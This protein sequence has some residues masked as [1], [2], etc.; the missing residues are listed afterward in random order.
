[1]RCGL[2]IALAMAGALQAQTAIPIRQL[3]P[4]VAS[5]TENIGSGVV[6]R[7]MSDGRL[8]LVSKSRGRIYLMDSTLRVVDLIRDSTAGTG[9]QGVIAGLVPYHGD[10]TLIPN[11][12]ARAML[13]VD[14]A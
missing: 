14:E 11:P 12:D 10:S 1:M 5:G 7:A 13:V 9:T 3:G 2:V 4:I 8:I 6:L